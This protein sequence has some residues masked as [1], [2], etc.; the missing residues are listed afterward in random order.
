MFV[1]ILGYIEQT[2]SY[3]VTRLLFS[4]KVK[5]TSPECS[6]KT[7]NIFVK[8]NLQS[9]KC[10]GLAGL[11]GSPEVFASTLYFP[12]TL[13]GRLFPNSLNHFRVDLE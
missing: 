5:V 1:A 2:T 7:S 13:L 11:T 3:T 12:N 8:N 6:L 4:Y 9:L 10:L